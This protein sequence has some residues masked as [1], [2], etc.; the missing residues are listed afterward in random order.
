MNGLEA[1]YDDL[2]NHATYNHLYLQKVTGKVFNVIAT[3][4][5]GA[6]NVDSVPGTRKGMSRNLCLTAYRQ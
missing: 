4:K 1:E 6:A 5:N 2:I 3:A